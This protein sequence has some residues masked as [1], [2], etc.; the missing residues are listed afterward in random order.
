MFHYSF[1]GI[2][3]SDCGTLVW[4]TAV[5]ELDRWHWGNG[6]EFHW[7]WHYWQDCF[8]YIV[9]RDPAGKQLC[10]MDFFQTCSLAVRRNPIKGRLW[11]SPIY[12]YLP[13]SS[14][15]QSFISSFLISNISIW[16]VVKGFGNVSWELAKSQKTEKKKNK[17]PEKRYR[18]FLP[19]RETISMEMCENAGIS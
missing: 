14:S 1:M 9:C 15:Q 3:L 8:R 13:L 17:T 18:G 10:Q 11:S 5:P 4:I 12:S 6:R 7:P 19:D 2:V 16:P